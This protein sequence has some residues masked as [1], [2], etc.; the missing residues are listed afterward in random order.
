MARVS[1]FVYLIAVAGRTRGAVEPGVHSRQLCNAVQRPDAGA[2]T[3][4]PKISPQ[5][6]FHIWSRNFG[7]PQSISILQLLK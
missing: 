1:L 2:K 4:A 5:I 7:H 6:S 3:E